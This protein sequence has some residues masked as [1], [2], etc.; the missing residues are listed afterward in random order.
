[1]P[2]NKLERLA[3]PDHATS[4]TYRPTNGPSEGQNMGAGEAIIRFKDAS[5]LIN[6]IT[7]DGKTYLITM[8]ALEYSSY[9]Y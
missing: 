3:D 8:N 1:M 9:H 2:L 6:L 7:G 4:V 5:H